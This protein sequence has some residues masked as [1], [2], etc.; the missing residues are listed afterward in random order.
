MVGRETAGRAPDVLVRQGQL[1]AR[2]DD[3]NELAGGLGFVAEVDGIL[4]TRERLA[5]QLEARRAARALVGE[6]DVNGAPAVLPHAVGGEVPV[7]AH[8][9]VDWPAAQQVGVLLLVPAEHAELVA[10]SVGL[11]AG[12]EGQTPLPGIAQATV[13]VAAA[14]AATLHRRPLPGGR[15][16]GAFVQGVLVTGALELVTGAVDLRA[17]GVGGQQVPGTLLARKHPVDVGRRVF[18]QVLQL[19]LELL[20]EGVVQVLG[21]PEEGEVRDPHVPLKELAHGHL[22]RRDRDRRRRLTQRLRHKCRAL[23]RPPALSPAGHGEEHA[24]RAVANRRLLRLGPGGPVLLHH[25]RRR[26][27]RR[28]LPLL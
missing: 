14:A 21:L 13:V 3:A 20:A 11:P 24:Q 7:V 16:G 1:H 26:T 4:I 28:M 10:A 23:V 5:Q 9:Y 6:V 12:L 25:R 18:A 2:L 17:E 8:P 22:E 27:R 15:G 19:P